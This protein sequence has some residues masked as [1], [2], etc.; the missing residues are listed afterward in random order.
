[1]KVI[2]LHGDDIIRSRT[3]L[4]KFIETAKKRGWKIERLDEA[5]FSISEKLSGRDLFKTESLFII[6]DLRKVKKSTLWWIMK[7]SAELPVTLIIYQE[8]TLAKSLL[9]KLPN[10]SKIEEFKLPRLIFSFLDAFYPGNAKRVALAFSQ[11]IQSQPSEFVVALLGRHLRD[12][13]W[14]KGDEST[15]QL[16]PWRIGKLK[17]QSERFDEESLR[18]LISSLAEIDVISKTTETDLA[19]SLDLLIATE[20]E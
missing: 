19:Y 11:I 3:R 1:M 14:V 17:A 7:K 10:D 6:Q 12:L 16:P 4:Q 18:N 9:L 13:Y 8:G 20:L 5:E 15:L 2:V